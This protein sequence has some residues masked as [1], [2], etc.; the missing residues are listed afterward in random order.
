[1]SVT[2]VDEFYNRTM[3]ILELIDKTKH[4][5]AHTWAG[6]QLKRTLVVIAANYFETEITDLIEKYL[7]RTTSGAPRA[8]L[9]KALERKYYKFFDWDKPNVNLFLDL[10]GKEFRIMACEEIDESDELKEAIKSFLEIGEMRNQIVHKR[11][12]D[13]TINKIVEEIYESYKKATS[14]VSFVQRKLQ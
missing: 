7:D 10:F 3:Q 1:M 4:P 14:F 6:E 13:V 12:E 5:I 2:R 9:K 11:P 8:I